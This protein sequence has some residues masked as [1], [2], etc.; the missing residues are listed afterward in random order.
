MAKITFVLEDGQEV[1]VPLTER[2]TIGRA[3]DSDVLVDDER[4]SMQHAELLQ[5]ADGSI[6]VFDFNSESGTFVNGER[7][8]SC[9]LL[10][11]DQIAFGP[12]IGRLDLEDMEP[13]VDT[14]AKPSHADKAHAE[15]M[16]RMEAEKARLKAAV[17]AVAKELRYWEKRAEKECSLHLARI[18]SL[19]AE[20]EQLALLQGAVRDA[21]AAHH[22]WTE[23]ISTLSAQYQEKTAALESL[24][25]RHVEKFSEVKRLAV[26]AANAQGD[27]QRRQEEVAEWVNKLAKVESAVLRKNDE[28]AACQKDLAL[29]EMKLAGQNDAL[30]AENRRIE[31]ATARRVEIER[32]HEELASVKQQLA[33]ACQ[34]LVAVEKRL[35]A[36]KMEPLPQLAVSKR[37]GPSAEESQA[38]LQDLLRQIESARQELG[39]L[40]GRITTLRDAPASVPKALAAEAQVTVPHEVVISAP[41]IVHVDPVRRASVSMKSE[42]AKAAPAS[43]KLKSKKD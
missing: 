34:Q 28:L 10:H 1:V 32:Q 2:I 36:A 25:V 43:T 17:D 15:E 37:K 8:K 4:I 9:T 21:E 22:E 5:N 3:E 40:Q 27:L 20:E 24:N 38:K 33:N 35:E 11:G 14:T 30:K 6:Q 13:P 19:R 12:L 41:L 16:A 23:A 18:E 31:Q 7:Q 29:C 42:R 39:D 26:E